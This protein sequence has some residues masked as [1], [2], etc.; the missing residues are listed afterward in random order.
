MGHIHFSHPIIADLE[1]GDATMDVAE[2][3]LE[4]LR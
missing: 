4:F 1:D 3:N 2:E